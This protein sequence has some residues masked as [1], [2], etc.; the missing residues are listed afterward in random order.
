MEK[1]R[2]LA[3]CVVWLFIVGALAIGYKF[4]V[5]PEQA[6]K[7]KTA[8]EERVRMAQTESE[9]LL[10]NTSSDGRY[11]H[12]IRFGID[13]FSGYSI[14]RSEG[15][16]KNLANKRIKISFE[17]D[18]ANYQQRL[19]KLKNGQIQMA[20]F[21]IDALIKASYI[22]KENPAT[23]VAMIDETRGA[24]AMVAYKS[25][26]PD[27][28]AL[29]SQDIEFVLTPD[30]PSETLT[31]VVMSH[32]NLDNL[33]KEPFIKKK[34]AEAVYNL[35]RSAKPIEK[36]AYLLWEPY[37]TKALENP[38]VHVVVDSSRFRGY[39]ADVIVVS[40]DFLV[41]NKET[42]NDVLKA[43]FNSVY[44][45]NSSM[46]ALVVKD[47]KEGDFFL[48]QK[49]ASRLVKGIWWK[50]SLE[51]FDQ[52]GLGNSKLQ[53][54]EDMISNITNVL[55]KSG[56]I[57]ADPTNGKPSLLYYSQALS[58]IKDEG[59]R[60]GMKGETVK[61]DTL[62]LA[63]L[64]G[65]EWNRLTPVGTLSVPKLVFARG[66]DR[67]SSISRAV[68]DELYDKLKTWPQYYLLVKGNASLR[69]D[70]QANQQ[71]A[72]SRAQTARQYLIE[73]GIVKHRIGAQGGKPSGSTS[74]SFVFGKKDY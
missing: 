46:E 9:R 44:Q 19:E 68:L 48:S 63:T 2:L 40:R 10:D 50:N 32:F 26:I 33:K 61:D 12:N 65:S 41:K 73:K 72:L 30:S 4:F 31:R 54:I 39:I 7:E 20:V 67:L 42:V 36:R 27:L 24:D 37:V 34:D 14:M 21:T 56:A 58:E 45:Y 51:N 23:I 47:A 70:L 71:L 64:Q 59:F 60:A 22:L 6:Q 38:N 8:D 11:K 53:H 18:G 55:L 13:S 3:A 69:G 17:D 35:Y 62:K 57:A 15:L 52:F 66:T 25:A 43:Y 16:I 74:V 29:N 49:A 28:D 5:A 1:G